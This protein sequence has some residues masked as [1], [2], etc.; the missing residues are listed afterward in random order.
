[1]RGWTEAGQGTYLKRML[2]IR[3]RMEAACGLLRIS[4]EGSNGR[5]GSA[6]LKSDLRGCRLKRFELLRLSIVSNTNDRDLKE[7]LEV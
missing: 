1:M 7:L 3:D 5:F 4:I 2:S 6:P